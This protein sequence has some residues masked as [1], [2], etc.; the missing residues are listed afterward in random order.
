M[1]GT[2]SQIHAA[3]RMVA[4]QTENG[5]FS[6]FELLEDAYFEIGDPVQWRNDT[7]LGSETLSNHRTNEQF[8]VF[9]QNH[10]VPESNLRKQLF[11]D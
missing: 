2:I 3:R 11:L 6:V 5:D 7:G 10:C 1:T 9:F 4:I 8:E